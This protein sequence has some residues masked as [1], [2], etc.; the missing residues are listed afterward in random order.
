MNTNILFVRIPKTGS[1]SFSSVLRR[2]SD[3]YG[4]HGADR[5][6]GVPEPFLYAR[7]AT[8][9]HSSS[10]PALA[11]ATLPVLKV[12]M[13]RQPV[14]RL[15]SNFYYAA[16]YSEEYQNM[17]ILKWAQSRRLNSLNHSIMFQ[18]LRS[19]GET[20]VQ[21]VL[22]QYAFIG[23]VERFDESI[24]LLM[25]QFGLGY[26]DVIYDSGKTSDHDIDGRRL[27]HPIPFSEQPQEVQDFLNGEAFR[28]SQ[29]EDFEAYDLA[30]RRMDQ[31][32]DSLGRDAFQAKV[33][34]FVKW[35]EDVLNQCKPA[36]GWD[37]S[38]C[39]KADF[40]CGYR[41][42]DDVCLKHPP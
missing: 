6:T 20:D 19:P 28:E 27:L 5:G 1:T 7:H 14:D 15:I 42:F 31:L 30:Q 4:V 34:D 13:I 18:Y 21:K 9:E 38:D 16:S 37:R 29:K 33:Q 12:T 22:D 25:E 24:V 2:V 26:C 39:Y 11:A 8:L 10:D 41:C 23:I 32:I 3:R 36:V 17:G 35:K 40:G